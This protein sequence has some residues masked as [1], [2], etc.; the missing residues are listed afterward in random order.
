MADW[1]SKGRNPLLPPDICIPDGEPHVFGDRLYVYGSWDIRKDDYCSGE[2]PVVS[3]EDMLQWTVHP[4]AFSLKD[5]PRQL[6]C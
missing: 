2:Y 5:I 4:L 1:T 6:L 3:T